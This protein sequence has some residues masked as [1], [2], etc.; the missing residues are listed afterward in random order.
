M[1]PRRD[2]V[3]KNLN[4]VKKKSKKVLKEL[5]KHKEIRIRVCDNVLLY[6]QN[7]FG[8]LFPSRLWSKSFKF[9]KL[10]EEGADRL[11]TNLDIVKIIRNLRNMRCLMKYSIMT[12]EIEYM[13]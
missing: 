4:S 1:Q 11:D 13:I 7:M 12:P 10:F 9:A 2:A 3:N 6:F 8:C 5:E